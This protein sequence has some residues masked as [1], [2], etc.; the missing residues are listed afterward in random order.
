MGITFGDHLI[1]SGYHDITPEQERSMTDEQEIL[2]LALE[3][4]EARAQIA[5]KDAALRKIAEKAGS[6]TVSRSVMGQENDPGFAGIHAVATA[7]LA[8]PARVTE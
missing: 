6:H 4:A 2:K 1:D 7:A 3:L 8:A 5:A